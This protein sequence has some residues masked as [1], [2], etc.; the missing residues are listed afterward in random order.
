MDLLLKRYMPRIEF[1]S[2]ED[3]RDNYTM[4]VPPDFN[5]GYDVVDAWAQAEPEKRALVWCDESGDEKVF[6]FTDIRRLSNQAANFFQAQGV[7]KG[8]VV[9][10]ILRR[11]WEYWVC[12]TALHKLGAV[13]IPGSLQLTKKDIAYRGN[14]AKIH[15]IVCV[16]DPF[17]TAQVEAAQEEMGTLR[18]KALVP[19]SRPGWL[20]FDQE[21]AKY[22]PD[23]QR[24]TGDK[25]RY[26]AGVFYLWH[27]GHA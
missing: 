19:G 21:M 5:F 23:F 22:P 18:F 9:M 3:F 27:H 11:R 7:G 26:H 24:P 20:D 6:T 13:L 4:N 16:D 15:G 12:A 1:D 2:Y 10:L 14:A 17:V 25:A 8:S